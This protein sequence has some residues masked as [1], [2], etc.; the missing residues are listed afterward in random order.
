MTGTVAKRRRDCRM[1][2]SPPPQMRPA[3]R[4]GN[5]CSAAAFSEA[6]FAAPYRDLLGCPADELESSTAGIPALAHAEKSSAD[7]F[8]L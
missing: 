3:R 6:S 4:L 5:P 2:G 1:G 7:A 8:T